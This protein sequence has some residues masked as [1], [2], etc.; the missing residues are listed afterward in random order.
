MSSQPFKQRAELPQIPGYRIEG[1]V[2]KGATGIVYRARQVSVNRVVALKV[3][4]RELVGAKSAEMRLQREA[5]TPA[6]LAHPNIISAID[7]GEIAGM[8]WYAMELVDGV[9]LAERL[10]DGA[11]SEREALRLFIPLCDALEHA[12][13]RGVVHRDIK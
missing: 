13:E 7:M 5:R 12:F 6:R 8:W 11:L 4:P 2:G 1:I 10:R 9:S 3:L